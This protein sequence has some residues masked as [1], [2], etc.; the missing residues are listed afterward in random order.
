MIIELIE[1]AEEIGWGTIAVVIAGVLM[2]IPTIVESW[3]KVLDALGLVKKKNLFRKQREKG[4][5]QS[6]NISRSCKVESC[7]SKRST[8]SNL[9]RSGITLPE[10]RM[11]CMK[12][13]LS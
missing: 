10:G 11:I 3:N 9:S 6:M 1:K 4:L 12:N 7:Q 2:F 13:K 5:Q 8:T